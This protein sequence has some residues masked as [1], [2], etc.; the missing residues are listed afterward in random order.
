MKLDKIYNDVANR[1]IEKIEEDRLIAYINVI[2]ENKEYKEDEY[3]RI[4]D[5]SVYSFAYKNKR[6]KQIVVSEIP[7]DET[8]FEVKTMDEV[9]D[10][11][12]NISETLY[13]SLKYGE[14]K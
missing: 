7:I 8:G 3:I 2:T 9:I 14:V 1:V 11:Q 13:Y 12:N 5:L 6:S 10:K 4:E